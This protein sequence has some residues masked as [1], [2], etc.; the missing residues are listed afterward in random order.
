METYKNYIEDCLEGLIDR[1]TDAN[2]ECE[3]NPTDFNKGISIAYYN[4]LNFLLG[5]AEVFEIKNK[6]KKNIIEYVPYY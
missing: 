2:H 4:V 3:N 1:A 5:Q 6:L